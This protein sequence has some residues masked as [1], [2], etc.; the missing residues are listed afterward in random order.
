MASAQVDPQ[1]RLFVQRVAADYARHGPFNHLSHVDARK[2]AEQVRAPWRQGGPTIQSIRETF[3]PFG[4]GSVRVR[5]YDTTNGTESLRPAL[6]YLHGGGWTIFSLDTHDRIMREY[7]NRSGVI[8]VGIDYALSPEAKFPTALEQVVE[9]V[10]WL[11]RRGPDFA[12]DPARI[13]I[14][15]DSAGGNLALAAALMLRD[16]HYAQQVIGILI[17]YGAFEDCSEEAERKY[18]GGRFMLSREELQE[19]WRNYLKS[20]GDAN[21]PLAQPL[22]ADLRGL[23]SV[24]LA[25]AECDILCEQNISM[26]TRLRHSGVAVTAHVY[27]GTTHSFLEAV[28]VAEVAVRALDDTAVWLK[29]VTDQETGRHA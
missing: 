13:V 23:P 10:R 14:G 11:H 7:A 5:I 22:K 8:V 24:F 25:I 1:I 12:I 21:N 2:V 16:G 17:N 18:G 28:S 4:G 6:V 20:P 27:P 3:V 19:F 29:H 9:V 15:G 26:A